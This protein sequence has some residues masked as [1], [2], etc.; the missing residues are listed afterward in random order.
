[1]DLLLFS[2]S[3]N[4]GE[5]YL[6]YT[7]PYI[8]EF[9]DRK[10]KHA[11]FIPFA[12]ISV[13]FDAYSEMVNE[14]LS[15]LGIDAEP[16]HVSGDKKKSISEADLIIIGGGNTFCLLKSMQDL[17]LISLIREKVLSGTPYIG[18]SA[19]SN[20]ACPTIKTTNDMPVVQP[21]NF[22]ALN[23]LPFQINPHYTDYVQKGHAG[24]SR[25][26]R[27]EEFLL[28]N[29]D[30]Y[31]V[32]LREGTALCFRNNMLQLQGTTPCTVFRYGNEP[33]E[34]AAGNNL[35]FLMQ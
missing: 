28:V 24:E 26:M 18:W 3:T 11:V 25:R 17:D 13:G 35:N 29:R 20:L 10:S 16:L 5:A 15:T 2:N 22:N 7:L 30:I 23:L 8:K 1:M 21:Y 4:S 31:V 19:G 27:I 32:G 12:G 6:H 14:K 34:V 33:F 9:S